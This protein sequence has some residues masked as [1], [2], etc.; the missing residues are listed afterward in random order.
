LSARFASAASSPANRHSSLAEKG[1]GGKDCCQNPVLPAFAGFTDNWGNL[2]P[3]LPTK[4]NR[5]NFMASKNLGKSYF[6]TNPVGSSSAISGANTSP[7]A[8]RNATNPM[9]NCMGISLDPLPQQTV[10]TKRR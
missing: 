2:P 4:K 8:I 10:R 6:R 5:D 1:S 7:S 9:M 3:N